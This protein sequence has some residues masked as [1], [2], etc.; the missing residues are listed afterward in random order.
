M[1][2]IL[3]GE[4]T[5]PTERINLQVSKTL[6]VVERLDLFYTGVSILKQ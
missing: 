2:I 3:R 6:N 4:N 1:K 5:D